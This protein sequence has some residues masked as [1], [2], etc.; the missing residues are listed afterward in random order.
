MKTIIT[1]SSKK[2]IFR[3]I[4]P[5][6]LKPVYSWVKDIEKEDT[7]IMMNASEPTSF[8]EEKEYFKT[9]FKKIKLKKVVKIAVFDGKKYLGSCDIEKLGKR[10]GHVGLFGIALSKECRGQG[11]GFKLAQETIL[12][13]KKKLGI[14]QITLSCFANNKI[15]ISFYQKLGFKQSCREPQ[16]VFFKGKYIDTIWFFKKLS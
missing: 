1:S 16:A 9:L 2:L 12:L 11:I 10:Q 8:K 6:D 3:Q 15:G 5:S 13:A 4:K 14:K 7:F